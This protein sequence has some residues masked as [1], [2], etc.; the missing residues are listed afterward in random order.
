MRLGLTHSHVLQMGDLILLPDGTVFLCNGVKIGKFYLT[1]VCSVKT[2]VYRQSGC[3][4]AISSV[5]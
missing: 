4:C 5:N 2:P 3:L 1:T